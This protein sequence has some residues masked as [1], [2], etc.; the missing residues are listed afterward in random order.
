MGWPQLGAALDELWIA[1]KEASP[2]TFH[3]R[4]SNKVYKCNIIQEPGFSLQSELL[5]TLKSHELRHPL[6]AMTWELTQDVRPASV[7]AFSICKNAMGV[8]PC[9][10]HREKSYSKEVCK[11]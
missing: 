3:L 1:F 7:H 11:S 10:V 9:S 5:H 6:R 4:T 2:S 8:P